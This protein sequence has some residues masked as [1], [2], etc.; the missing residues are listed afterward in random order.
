MIVWICR[1]NLVYSQ[2]ESHDAPKRK[3][4]TRNDIASGPVDDEVG[5]PMPSS[6]VD[7]EVGQLMPSSQPKKSKIANRTRSQGSSE[8][9]SNSFKTLKKAAVALAHTKRR[10]NAND[11]VLVEGFQQAYRREIRERS[12][13]NSA[14]SI[15]LDQAIQLASQTFQQSAPI[16]YEDPMDIDDDSSVEE[17][18][19]A[20]DV[21]DDDAEFRLQGH[22]LD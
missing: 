5:Q 17:D 11:R 1:T 22:H 8:V 21:D 3:K 20:M 12:G 6:T 19:D 18:F 14:T 2:S 15:P 13:T 7:D 9:V 10:L 16:D 4:R